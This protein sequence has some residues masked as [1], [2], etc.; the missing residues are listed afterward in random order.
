MKYNFP[1]KIIREF[2]R[3]FDNVLEY[4]EGQRHSINAE[5]R[6]VKETEL[7][8]KRVKTKLL[9]YTVKKQKFW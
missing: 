4:H 7:L 9:K 1:R 6:R 8:K 3:S 2:I 5:H